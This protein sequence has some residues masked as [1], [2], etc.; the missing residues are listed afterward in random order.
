MI[1][2]PIIIIRLFGNAE[3]F[4]KLLSGSWEF[5]PFH[6]NPMTLSHI[7][8]IYLGYIWNIFGIYLEYIWDIFCAFCLFVITSRSLVGYIWEYILNIF[9]IYLGYIWNIC[10]ALLFVCDN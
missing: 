2:H 3:F 7:F 8:G 1:H 6:L 5:T 4:I 9:W 10:A